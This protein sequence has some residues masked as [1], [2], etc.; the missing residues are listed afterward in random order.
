[1]FVALRFGF[2]KSNVGLGSISLK[3]FCGSYFSKN[4]LHALFAGMCNMN[5]YAVRTVVL[6]NEN[7]GKYKYVSHIYTKHNVCSSV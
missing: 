4:H 1:M 5:K 6:M 3:Q 2:R 7:E